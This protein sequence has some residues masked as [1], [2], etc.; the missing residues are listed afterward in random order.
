MQLTRVFPIF[1][2]LVALFANS[3]SAWP[4]K[5]ANREA[6]TTVT[7]C[8]EK[9]D[10]ANEYKLTANG[11]TYKL[12]PSGNIN[13]ADHVGHKVSVTGTKSS[14]STGATAKTSTGNMN[15]E[16]TVTNVKHISDKCQ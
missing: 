12:M 11:K 1:L 13:L 10:G 4:R 15:Q 6:K 5:H 7:G 9:G 14:E 3:A 2:M 8:L 16:L